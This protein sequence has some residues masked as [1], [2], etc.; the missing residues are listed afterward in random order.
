MKE[1]PEFMEVKMNTIWSDHVQGIMTL[2][3]SRK[4]RF[5]DM[6]F[7]Q[8]KSL[9]NLNHITKLRILEIGCGPGAFAESMHK[10]YPDAHITAIDRDSNFISFAKT[11]ITGVDFIEG[12]AAKLPFEDHSFDVTISNTVLEHVEPTAFWGEQRRVLKSGGICLC[13]SA[14]KGLCCVAPCL[15]ITEKEKRFWESVPQSEDDLEKFSVCRFPMS[16]SEI[17]D[18][19][20]KN[21]FT[22]VTTGYAIIDLTPDDSKY[23]PEM[24]ELMIEAKRQTE[25]EAVQSVH[26]DHAD[27]IIS[28]INS[29]YDERLRLYREGIKQWD[30]SVSVTMIIRGTKR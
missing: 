17:P 16:E 25:I 19:M 28:V 13:L 15:E 18:S 9:F 29:K 10:W 12:D 7:E 14:R 22:N 26:S 21:G 5:N 8:Y 2:Y 30:T 3:L 24:A 23:P 11:N 6:F 20:E 27:E 1:K 4:L